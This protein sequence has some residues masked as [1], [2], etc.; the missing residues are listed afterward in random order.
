MLFDTLLSSKS[1]PVLLKIFYDA[2]IINVTDKDKSKHSLW[3]N[4]VTDH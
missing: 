1:L 3:S 2:L 4:I